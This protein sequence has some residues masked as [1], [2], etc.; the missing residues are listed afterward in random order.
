M[1]LVFLFLLSAAH[2][3]SKLLQVPVRHFF[4]NAWQ[5]WNKTNGLML[6]LYCTAVSAMACRCPCLIWGGRNAKK[7][8]QW[9]STEWEFMWD[10][11]PFSSLFELCHLQSWI[12]SFQWNDS[13]TKDQ[14]HFVVQNFFIKDQLQEV[15]FPSN[16]WRR[17]SYFEMLN[18]P[19]THS[20][21]ITSG[22][23]FIA[24][25]ARLC[26][27]T[28]SII[29]K[30]EAKKCRLR[31]HALWKVQT[32]NWPSWRQEKWQK[33]SETLW[34]I[35]VHRSCWCTHCSRSH[36]KCGVNPEFECSSYIICR[37][38]A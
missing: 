33:Q 23:A 5:S 2:C 38:T 26:A 14:M 25:S 10:A 15:E 4:W 12:H 31:I 1:Q 37:R 22:C 6:Q 3:P 11:M 7:K 24:K 30:I 20:K 19:W 17:S 21:Q 8:L 16:G 34:H 32:S 27:T 35:T 9:A 36:W 28:C 13:W 29:N 18:R